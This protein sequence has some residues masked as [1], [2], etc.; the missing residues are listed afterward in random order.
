[1]PQPSIWGRLAKPAAAAVLALGLP[2]AA[3]QESARTVA[4]QVAMR[5]GGCSI[6]GRIV[7]PT[8]EPVPNARILVTDKTTGA[9]RRTISDPTGRFIS[10]DLAPGTYEI[11]TEVPGFRTTNRNVTLGEGELARIDVGMILEV[12]L[13]EQVAVEGIRTEPRTVT[14]YER[15]KPTTYVAGTEEDRGSLREIARL[16]YRDPGAWLAIFAANRD[17][18]DQADVVP[19]GLTLS[20][21]KRKPAPPKPLRKVLPAHPGLDGEVVLE[22]TLA[23]NGSVDR[24]KALVGLP[25]LVELATQAVKQWRYR[26]PTAEKAVRT[27]LVSVTF[28][29]DGTVE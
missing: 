7:D 28:D 14:L 18:L 1:M 27:F 25:P 19:F 15:K 8:G 3:L 13:C 22:V 11:R 16:A 24:V 9:Q 23:G 4:P 26:P 6:S 29:K 10:A 5:S 20:I 17:I 12:G 2:A 21:P